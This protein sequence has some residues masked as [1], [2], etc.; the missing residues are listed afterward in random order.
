MKDPK[1]YWDQFMYTVTKDEPKAD[2]FSEWEN[3]TDSRDEVT[4]LIW[5]QYR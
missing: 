3:K 2:S 1:T 5:M 4:L